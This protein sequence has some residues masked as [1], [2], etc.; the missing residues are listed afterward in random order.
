MWKYLS[1][2]LL[3]YRYKTMGM[4]YRGQWEKRRPLRHVNATPAN[5][6]AA[7]V[8]RVLHLVKSACFAGL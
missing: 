2:K 8:P 1:I 3:N 6:V 7:A 5:T 4:N